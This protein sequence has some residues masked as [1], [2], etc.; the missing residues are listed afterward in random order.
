M[1]ENTCDS[2]IFRR[3]IH[4][5]SERTPSQFRLNFDSL[6]RYLLQ[7]PSGGERRGPC[8]LLSALLNDGLSRILHVSSLALDLGLA[9]VPTKGLWIINYKNEFGK[10]YFQT[11]SPTY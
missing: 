8:S 11:P 2:G 1:V 9:H 3:H 7:H 6:N 5:E 10:P 4:L